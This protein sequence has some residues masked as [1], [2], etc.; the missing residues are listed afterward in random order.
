MIHF[1]YPVYRT[2]TLTSLSQVATKEAALHQCQDLTE[3]GAH[4]CRRVGLGRWVP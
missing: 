1:I 2:Q 4:E 3:N